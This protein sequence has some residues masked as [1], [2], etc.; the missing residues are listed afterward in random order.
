MRSKALQIPLIIMSA[1]LLANASVR[2]LF[3]LFAY[4][5]RY[6]FGFAP[7]VNF[8]IQS[9]TGIAA[10]VLILVAAIGYMGKRYKLFSVGLIICSANSI[11]SAALYQMIMLQDVKFLFTGESSFFIVPLPSI[12]AILLQLSIHRK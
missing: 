9:L 1:L 5:I 4:Y 7:T 8:L 6:N 12:V 2:F 3:D 10:C 11:L